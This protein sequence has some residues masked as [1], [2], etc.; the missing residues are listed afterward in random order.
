MNN[1]QELLK[2]EWKNVAT[3]QSP[4]DVGTRETTEI[5]EI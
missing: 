4:S 3:Y 5:T 1:I 2:G